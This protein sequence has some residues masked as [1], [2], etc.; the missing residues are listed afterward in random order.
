MASHGH[1]LIQQLILMYAELKKAQ[2]TARTFTPTTIFVDEF[3]EQMTFNDVTA[4]A[5]H[6]EPV[7]YFP[8]ARMPYNN[9]KLNENPLTKAWSNEWDLWSIGMI[10]LEIIVGTELVLLLRP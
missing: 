2:V 4:L 1:R 8:E 3:C 7:L 10:A 5:Y 9:R 6:H